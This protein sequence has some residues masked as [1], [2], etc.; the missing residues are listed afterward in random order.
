[1]KN[2]CSHCQ[3]PVT[4]VSFVAYFFSAEFEYQPDSNTS[5][6][7]IQKYYRYENPNPFIARSNAIQAIRG[8]KS[9]LDKGL[10]CLD[11]PYQYESIKLWFEYQVEHPSGISKPEI[12]KLYLLDGEIGTLEEIQNR[13]E[14]E[15]FMLDKMGF[16]FARAEIQVDAEMEY[17]DL[18]DQLFDGLIGLDTNHYQS[19]I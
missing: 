3:I 15:E 5:P 1:M 14:G 12:R 6:K 11:K 9:K 19:M 4:I 13:L 10:A 7:V 8:I 18:V 17:S 16:S 2:K